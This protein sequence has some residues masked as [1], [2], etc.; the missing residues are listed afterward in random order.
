[1]RFNSLCTLLTMRKS[2]PV[3]QLQEIKKWKKGLKNSKVGM[4]DLIK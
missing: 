1:M 2:K 3:N 4:Y